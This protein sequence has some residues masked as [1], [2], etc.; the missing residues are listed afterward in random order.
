MQTVRINLAG[1]GGV[2][3]AAGGVDTSG[4]GGIG[5]SAGGAGDGGPG[6]GSKRSHEDDDP[7][8]D[9]NKCRKTDDGSKPSR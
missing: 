6:R 3:R 9:P 5:G 1:G 7:D 8:D 4:G 2:G